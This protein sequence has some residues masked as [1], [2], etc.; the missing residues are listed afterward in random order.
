[1]RGR[2]VRGRRLNFRALWCRLVKK[3]EEKWQRSPYSIRSSL[4]VK[5]DATL[6][7]FYREGNMIRLQP[8]NQAMQ[9]IYVAASDLIVQGKVVAL[10]RRV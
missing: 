5:G 4:K 10:I 1:M 2:K 3:D 6:K 8:A 9:P 7:R